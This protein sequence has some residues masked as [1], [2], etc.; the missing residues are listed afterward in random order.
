MGTTEFRLVVPG[1]GVQGARSESD[2]TFLRSRLELGSDWY[3]TTER[4][5]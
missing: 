5:F 4:W 2:S 1:R 3:S